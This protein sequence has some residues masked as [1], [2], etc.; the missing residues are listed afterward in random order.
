MSR[1]IEEGDV[2]T[3]IETGKNGFIKRTSHCLVKHTPA[4]TGD[5]WY[6][7]REGVTFAINSNCSTFAGFV[8]EEENPL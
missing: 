4:D 6:L 1:T 7:E 2:V 3:M 8:K 5:L